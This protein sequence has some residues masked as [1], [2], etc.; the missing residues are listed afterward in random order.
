MGQP[1]AKR[2]AQKARHQ[3]AR[4]KVEEEGE[5]SE[6]ACPAE[7][8]MII[9]IG[10][11]TSVPTQMSD[12]PQYARYAINHAD[13]NLVSPLNTCLLPRPQHQKPKW[14]SSSLPHCSI[15]EAIEWVDRMKEVRD[16]R[17]LSLHSYLSVVPNLMYIVILH[18]L[19]YAQGFC[20][21]LV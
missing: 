5:T 2:Q 19:I 1:P 3:A 4:G 18:I 13:E 17:L 15:C 10:A 20:N 7:W 16:R 12:P 9:V 11:A 21:R 8:P 6:S 14:R